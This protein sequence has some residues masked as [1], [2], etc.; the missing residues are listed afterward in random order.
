MT[1]GNK[2]IWFL[3]G[4]SILAAIVFLG[5]ICSRLTKTNRQLVAKIINPTPSPI[6]KPAVSITP[7]IEIKPFSNKSRI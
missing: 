3:S 6:L 7:R 1:N 2:L 4:I 5:V